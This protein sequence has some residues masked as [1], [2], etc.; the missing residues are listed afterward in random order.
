M[1]E[2]VGLDWR[3]AERYVGRINAVT[4][5]QVRQVAREFLRDER[6]TVA[7]LEPLPLNI[8]DNREVK[9]AAP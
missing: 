9:H 3:E 1:L 6:L 5:E 8:P 4:P 2:T 7:I